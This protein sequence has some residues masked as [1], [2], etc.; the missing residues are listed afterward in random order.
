MSLPRRRFLQLAAGAAALPALARLAWA[1]AYPTRPV[2]LIVPFAPGGPTDVFARL[3][4][5]KFSEQF[6]KQFYVEN[7]VGGAGNIGSAQAARAAPDGY[8][9]LL[10]VSAF[11]T[12]PAF[13]G[14]APY[15]PVKDFAPVALPIASAIALVVHPSVPAK[16]MTDFVALI[17]ANPGKY[18]YATGGAGAQPH[19]AFEQFRLSLGL[20]IVHV[21]FTGAGPAV[22]AVV[23]NQVPI[24]MSSLPPA[25]PQLQGGTLRALALTSKKRSRKLPDIPTVAEA[26]YPILEGDQ[27][28]GI[29][30]PTGTPKEIIDTLHRKTVELVAQADMQERLEALD[31]YPIESTPEEFAERV[32]VELETWRRLVKAAN[33][34][35][36]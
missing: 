4:A 5:Q 9:I 10:N 36:E 25:V 31:F 21:P 2:R 14:K 32:K 15:D 28:L 13:L 26:G 34:K 23:A 12:N 24:G 29:L 16:T 18:S 11:V 22:A 33:I 3:I 7:V 27:W 6:G 20:D 8:T 35:A 17:R 19:L 30:V 1:Q